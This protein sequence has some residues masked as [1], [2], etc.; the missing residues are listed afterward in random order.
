M[1][2]YELRLNGRLPQQVGA[3]EVTASTLSNKEFYRLLVKR[4]QSEYFTIM[5]DIKTASDAFDVLVARLLA[6]SNHSQINDFLE[7][8]KNSGAL[9]D[10][11]SIWRLKKKIQDVSSKASITETDDLIRELDNEIKNVGAYL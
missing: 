1:L 2:K 11:Q 5:A 6:Q 3:P 10:S 8:L 9:K 7:E 4:Y